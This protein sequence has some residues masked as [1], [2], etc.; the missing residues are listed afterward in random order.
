[1]RFLL[2]FL[3]VSAPV[4]SAQAQTIG[5]DTARTSNTLSLEEAI[6]IARR[7][8][9]LYL[10]SLSQRTRADASVRSAYGQLL[11]QADASLTAL[12]Q[13]GGRQIFNG[14][15]FGA[16]SDVNQS[17][18]SIGVGY[19]INMASVLAPKV[20]R[21]N[22]DAVEADISASGENLRTSVV[23]QYLSVLQA[24]ENAELQDTLVAAAKAQVVLAQARALVGSGTQLDVSRAEVTL[25]QAQVQQLQA[26]NSIEVEKLKLFAQMGIPKNSDVNLTTQFT[27]APTNL[28]LNELLST[29]QRDNPTVLA[30]RSREHVAD[31]NV[32]RERGEY[33]PT[34]SL[35]TGLSGYTYA[36]TNPN[37]PVEQ[38]RA[39]AT[40]GKAECIRTEEVRAALGLSNTLAACNAITFT[41]AMAADIRKQNGAFP[42][43][44]TKSPK[45]ISAT[46]SIPI[47]D[48]F[49]RE[50]RMQE[51]QITRNNLKNQVRAAEIQL[52]SG[53]TSAYL[54]LT[55]AQQ[56]VALQEQNSAKARQELKLM[57]DR[58]RAGQ[59]TFVDLSESRAA[60]ERAE[61]ERINAIYDY[62]KAFALLENAVGRPL[63]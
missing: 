19:R 34:L 43:D 12:R 22:R 60:Y 8:N 18:Y 35:N 6:S 32:K 14:G 20:Q 2:C 33:T 29:A 49:S 51:A 23:Q 48:G 27:I 26:R 37:F 25:G 55:T 41:D 31:L 4:F 50:Q 3:A 11:P 28:S 57:Q 24:Q 40:A 30:L 10:E 9:Y 39:Q 61:S 44:F 52:T 5:R 63:R 36:Y 54:T 58:Y 7:N 59:A 15:S 1:M 45:S 13:Q 53:I 47:F 17:Q 42:F 46:L 16:S 62:H 38:A 56:T 21:A